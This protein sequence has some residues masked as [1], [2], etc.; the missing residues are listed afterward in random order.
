MFIAWG[1]Q[2]AFLYNDASRLIHGDTGY[3]LGKPLRTVWADIWDQIGGMMEDCLHGTAQWH[4]NLHLSLHRKGAPEDAWF[5]FS[6]APLRD[7]NEVVQGIL[8]VASETTEAVLATRALT[9]SE[10]RHRAIVTA[11]PECVKLV[12]TDG[13]LLEMNPVGLDI[14]EAD[15]AAAVLG[16]DILDVIAPE[17]REEWRRNHERVCHGESLAW[18]FDII[19]LK[20][21]RRRMETHAVPLNM[22]DG[23]VAQLAV[24]RDVTERR[25]SEEHQKLLVNE[26]NHRVKNTLATVQSIVS[27][28]LRATAEPEKAREQIEGRL[29]ALSGAHSILTRENWQGAYVGELVSQIMMPFRAQENQIAVQGPPIRLSPKMAVSISL[30]LQELATNA[31]KYGAFSTSEGRVSLEWRVTDGSNLYLCWSEHGGPEVKKPERSG[32]GTRLIQSLTE[33]M[34][35]NVKMD[36]APSGFTGILAAPISA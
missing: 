15:D 1:P 24:T 36:F 3:A 14:I 26:L 16:H 33:E 4:E 6:F 25:K 13:R 2:L 8:C 21:T 28:T 34:G 7:E 12:S 35:G 30:M 23:S 29:I 18:E 9:K 10:A 27:H 17:D 11:T 31:I 32:F 19:G 22:P 5:S 20:G